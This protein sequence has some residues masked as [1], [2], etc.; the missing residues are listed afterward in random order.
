M[1]DDLKKR[2]INV[3]I[4]F[5]L[6]W[7]SCISI[8]FLFSFL[9]KPQLIHSLL[10]L[11]FE[12]ILCFAMWTFFMIKI[13]WLKDINTGKEIN[14]LNI[15][16]VLSAIR[17]SLVPMLITMFGIV[18]GQDSSLYIKIMI[19]SFTFFVCLTD[20]FDGILA[21]KFNEVTKLGM[22][23]DPIGD[24]L[25]ITCFAVLVFSKGIIQWWF[26]TLV[27]IR[28]PLLFII[29]VIM[30]IF[31]IKFKI[32]TSI[33]GKVTV[34]YT[35]ALLGISTIKLFYYQMPLFYDYFLLIAQIVGCVIIFLSSA[36]KILLL[37][38]YLKN[39]D[40]LKKEDANL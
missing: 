12:T 13:D 18:N 16:N 33:L 19:F 2:R 35:V 15:S 20:F 1:M 22:I 38:D 25:M 29:M 9:I 5:L 37:S 34:F 23:L 21:R 39:Q 7:I 28:I 24:F 27:M 14:Y 8:Y 32:K 30:L 36:E 4:S 40:K 17:F 10:I 11:F 31:K 6:I 26:F 3:S